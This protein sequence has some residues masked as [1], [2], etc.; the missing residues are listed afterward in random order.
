MNIS[1]LDFWSSFDPNNNFFTHLFKEIQENINITNATDADIIIFSCF[2][3]ENKKYNHCKKIFFTG[4][5]IRPNFDYC[6]YSFTFDFD[7]F[8]GKNIRIPLWYLYIDWFDVK[9]YSDP[10]CLIPVNFLN[11]TIN[12][13]KNKFCATVFSKPIQSRFE[14][15]NKIQTYKSV[16]CYGKIHPNSLPDGEDKKLDI[17]SNYKFSICFENSIYPGYFTEKLLHAKIAGTIPLYYS[18]KTFSEDFN[19]KCCLN[20][21]NYENFDHFLEDIKE[22]D[23]NDE[24]YQEILNQPLFNNKINLD[25]IKIKIKKII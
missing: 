20:V 1:F 7:D 11:K 6:D 14:I 2:G 9:S 21:I 15:I 25:D 8:N 3:E 13:K 22:I 5:N 18:D 4:E 19:E 16:D 10:S 23:N 24:K 12:R 17:L